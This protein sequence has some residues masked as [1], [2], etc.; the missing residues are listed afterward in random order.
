MPFAVSFVLVALGAVV[1]H[2]VYLFVQ[3]SLPAKVHYV[4]V[5]LLEFKVSG[6]WYTINT[7]PSPK[8]LL[9]LLLLHQVMEIIRLWFRRTIPFTHSSRLS[10]E[11]MLGFANSKPWMCDCVIADLVSQGHWD[12]PPQGTLGYVLI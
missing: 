5:S 3:T 12:H 11:K 4:N 6:L 1:Y 9:Y 10:M 8:L 2:A 7:G